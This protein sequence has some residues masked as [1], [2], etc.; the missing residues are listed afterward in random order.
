MRKTERMWLKAA[1][2]S[3]VVV[4]GMAYFLQDIFHWP[5]WGHVLLWFVLTGWS[6]NMDLKAEARRIARERLVNGG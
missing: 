1:L 6:Y 3:A 2:V 4:G 5:W